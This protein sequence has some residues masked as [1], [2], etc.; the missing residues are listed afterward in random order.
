MA[1]SVKTLNL[2]YSFMA[3]VMSALAFQYFA[4]MAFAGDPSITKVEIPWADYEIIFYM[5]CRHVRRCG[6]HN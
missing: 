6:C 5:Q 3:L 1:E 2:Y 4:S